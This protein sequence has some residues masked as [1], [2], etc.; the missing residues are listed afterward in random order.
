MDKNSKI[1]LITHRLY[2]AYIYLF[3]ALL[4]FNVM[5]T[6]MK[7]PHKHIK[8]HIEYYFFFVHFCYADRCVYSLLV[9]FFFTANN[10]KLPDVVKIVD[11]PF[12][13]HDVGYAH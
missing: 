4:I 7:S 5:P 9:Y 8:R 2:N 11:L 10:V 1:I 6:R 12:R 3:V 13:S